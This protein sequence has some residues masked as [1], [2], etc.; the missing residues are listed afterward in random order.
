VNDIQ[1]IRESGHVTG[2]TT[3][4]GNISAPK[5][6]IAAGAGSHLIGHTAGIELPIVIRPRQSFTTGWRH[7][8]FPEHGPMISGSAP[9]PHVRQEAQSGAIFGWKYNWHNKN[10]ADQLGTN[11]A[12]NA[13]IDPLYPVAP[14]KDPHFP[15]IALTLLAR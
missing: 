9:F 8:E 4:A 6:V 11:D 15:S 2:V 14:L 5:I 7:P 1:I 10:V 13:I 3:S 12:H